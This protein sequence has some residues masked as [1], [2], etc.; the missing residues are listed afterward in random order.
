VD[1]VGGQLL[2]SLMGRWGLGRQ[3]AS[4]HDIFLLASP[5]MQPFA[6]ALFALVEGGN[7]ALETAHPGVFELQG[8]L[9]QCLSDLPGGAVLP[10]HSVTC[11]HLILPC[12]QEL[13]A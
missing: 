5:A 6:K 4:L 8:T 12:H 1:R 3:L 7:K 9:E 2:G 10:A 13:C 11:E